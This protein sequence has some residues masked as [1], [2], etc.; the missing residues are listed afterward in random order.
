ML[1]LTAGPA[2]AAPKCTAEPPLGGRPRFLGASAPVSAAARDA[3]L[4]ME[5][6]K[7]LNLLVVITSQSIHS[8]RW[9]LWNAP[10][11]ESSNVD[12]IKL[13]T[14]LRMSPSMPLC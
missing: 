10:H 11:L 2:A 6:S 4:R 14:L 13:W 7:A 12:S 1:H 5:G 3:E 8:H 9:L